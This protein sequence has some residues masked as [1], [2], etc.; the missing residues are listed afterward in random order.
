MIALLLA[1]L[2]QDPSIE[3]TWSGTLE[4]QGY[5]LRVAFHVASKDG[6]LVAT[7]DSI[8]QGIKGIAVESVEVKAGAVTIKL[9]SIGGAFEGRLE[10]DSIEGTWSQSGV[11]L[12]LELR[13]VDKAPELNRPQ[14]PKPPFPYKV[15]EVSYDNRAGGVRFAGTLTRPK[16]DGPFPAVLLI[17]GSGAQDR[18]E[19]LFG[20]KPFLVLA[21][22]LTRRG[23]AVLRV[24]DRGVGGSTGD[25]LDATIDDLVADALAG[26]A[27]LKARAAVDPK[28][29]GLVGHSEGGWVAPL[30]ATKSKDVAYI[31][32][33]AGPG[34][35]GEEIL[36]LQTAAILRAGEVDE[37][38]IDRNRA[39]ME[40]TYSVVKEES[41][42]ARARARLM[43]IF[44]EQIAGLTE[45]QARAAGPQMEAQLKTLTSRWFR[46]ILTYDPRPSL[47]RVAC[48]VLAILGEKD[49]Q[50]PAAENRA[51]LV[52]AFEEGGNKAARVEVLAGHNH[53][54]QRCKTGLPAEY[55]SLEETMSP[56]SLDLIAEWLLETAK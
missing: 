9:P 1:T 53:L 16:G 37:E 43:E 39:V 22:A 48:P 28:R 8:D 14:T 29:I 45:E 52:K 38:T 35:S 36:H 13:R 10:G 40:R 11:S 41:D 26:V 51:E 7:L 6:R 2:L 25:I 47:R 21:D 32:M 23:F 46:S 20:H 44:K 5:K 15:E 27:F 54:L 49:L 18:D 56:E 12:P 4:V 17:T 19:T 33:I 31:A 50:V 55:G 3:G 30:A 24:D 42:D 34:L